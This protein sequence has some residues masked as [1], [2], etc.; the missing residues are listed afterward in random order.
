M[1]DNREARP[2][3]LIPFAASVSGRAIFAPGGGTLFDLAGRSFYSLLRRNF[4]RSRGIF[5]E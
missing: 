4:Y 1:C 3:L 2:R 5:Y